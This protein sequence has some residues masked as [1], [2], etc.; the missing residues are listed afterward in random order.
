MIEQEHIDEFASD[1]IDDEVNYAIFNEHT[2]KQIK[3]EIYQD[4]CDDFGEVVSDE[5]VE[6][7]YK[8]ISGRFYKMRP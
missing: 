3:A 4:A 6:D 8:M 1:W 2:N 7:L 5:L